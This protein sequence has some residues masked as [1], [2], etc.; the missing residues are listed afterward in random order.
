[1]LSAAAIIAVS[2]AYCVWLWSGGRRTLAMKTWRLVLATASGEPVTA[3]RALLRYL[4][5]WVGAAL[6]VVS[7]V[8]LQ[9]YAWALVD[10][11]RRFLQD[12]AAGT[13]LVIES[14]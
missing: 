6:A 10:R 7:F 8:P 2:A 14:R 13:R 1:M 4:A 9:T 3:R 5:C 11:E 12:R